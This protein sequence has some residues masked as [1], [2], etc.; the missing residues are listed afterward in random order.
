M[1]SD[2]KTEIPVLSSEVDVRT[3]EDSNLSL[4]RRIKSKANVQVNDSRIVP[5]TNGQMLVCIMFAFSGVEQDIALTL[6]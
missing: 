1:S 4:W 2:G 5:G 3:Y 6:S